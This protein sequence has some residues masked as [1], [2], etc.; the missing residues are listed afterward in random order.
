MAT[1]I[2][3]KI[4]AANAE[5]F[6]RITAADPVLVDILPAGQAV[7]GLED[8]MVLHSGPPVD[9]EQMCG[10]QRGRWLRW[11]CSR[12]GPVISPKRTRC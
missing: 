8:R 1:E 9:W 5:A 6:N 2:R 12:A 4:Q 11:S 10:A 7:P 3:A